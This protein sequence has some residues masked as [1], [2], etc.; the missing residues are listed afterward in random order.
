MIDS[1]EKLVDEGKEIESNVEKIKNFKGPPNPH[2]AVVKNAAW[3]KKSSPKTEKK[4]HVEQTAAVKDSEKRKRQNNSPQKNNVQI[5]SEEKPLR[6]EI[7]HPDSENMPNPG[8]CWKC[9]QHG[10]LFKNC[11]NDAKFKYFRYSC[12]KDKVTVVKC[13]NCRNKQKENA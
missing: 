8:E 10:D 5:K 9:R 4:D 12:G 6:T 2:T 1:F 7:P 3:P 13:P 11:T